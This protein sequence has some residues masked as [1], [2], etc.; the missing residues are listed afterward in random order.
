MDASFDHIQMGELITSIY[1]K[2]LYFIEKSPTVR[3][4]LL[5]LVYPFQSSVWYCLFLCIFCM[6][7]TSY[8]L[9]KV[10]KNKLQQMI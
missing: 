2:D 7:T 6:I 4:P 10:S 3:A 9:N 8:F 1:N 5:N